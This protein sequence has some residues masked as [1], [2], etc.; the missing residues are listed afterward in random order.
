MKILSYAMVRGF[1]FSSNFRFNLLGRELPNSCKQKKNNR[2]S[3][4]DCFVKYL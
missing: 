4:D 3:A 1:G 2:F